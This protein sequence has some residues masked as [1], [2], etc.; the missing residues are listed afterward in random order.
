MSSKQKLQ[1]QVSF[2]ELQLTQAKEQM[3]SGETKSHEIDKLKKERLMHQ[4]C[5]G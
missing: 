1:D 3:I 2:L 4:F 5:D